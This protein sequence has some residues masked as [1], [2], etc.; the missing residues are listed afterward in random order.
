MSTALA[1]QWA[2]RSARKTQETFVTSY[3]VYEQTNWVALFAGQD[4]VN[5]NYITDGCHATLSNYKAITLHLHS[6]AHRQGGFEG[7]RRGS[8]LEPPF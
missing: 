4:V 7:V 6:Q 1:M 3:V 5:S 8:L 2:E